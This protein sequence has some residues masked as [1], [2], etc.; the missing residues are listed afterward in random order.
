[1][2]APML[3]TLADA[4]LVDPALVYEPKYDGMR[5]IADV[6]A[7]GASVTLWSRLGNNKTTQFPE[8]V[9][10][11]A[12]WA[13]GKGEPIVL[14]GELVALDAS[15]QPAGFGQLQG[16]LQ[17]REALPGA[18]PTA[19]IAFDL[20]RIGTHDLRDHP[21]SVR[22]DALEQLFGRTQHTALRLSEQVAGDGR[23]L[24]ERAL[25]SGWEGL[26]AKH[27]QSKYRSG[28]RSADWRKL[29][30]V[31][32]QEFVVCGWTAPRQSRTHFGALVL[33]VH[34]A[35]TLR[36]AGS[37]GTGFDEQE[38]ARLMA[39]LTP[40]ETG[41][42]PFAD[43]PLASERP[44]WVRPELVVQVK[45]SEWTADHHLRHPVYIGLRTDAPA[46]AVV[47][48]SAARLHASTTR[49]LP[50]ATAATAH[51]I[52]TDAVGSAGTAE[53]TD[54]P[55]NRTRK[56]AARSRAAAAP[57]DA[58]AQADV[59]AEPAV[60]APSDADIA[61]LLEQVDA[62]ERKRRDGVL[63]LPDGTSLAVTNLTKLFWPHLGLTKGDLFRYYIQAAP[64]ILPVLADRALVMKRFPNGVHGDP[65]YQHRA[66][67]VPPGI[68]VQDIAAADGQPQ[69]VG[70]DLATLLYTCQLAAI[71]QDPWFSQVQTSATPDAMALDL[72]PSD[73]VPFEQVLDVARWIREELQTFGVFAVPKT[74]G[75][76]GL[77]IFVPL[78]PGT[79][80]EAGR[81]FC[82]IVA[83]LV[84]E[85]HPQ[86]ATIERTVRA[87]GA[88]VY[89]DYLQNIEGKTLASAY[90]ARASDYA[91]VST[92]L[93]W[94]EVQ[95]GVRREDFTISTVPTRLARVGDLWAPLRQHPGLDLRTIAGA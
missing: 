91:G 35:G 68:R 29:K 78:T 38:L 3:A 92:P 25:A 4:P 87:R 12:T 24:Y 44:H 80:Y 71:S 39:L 77:H 28:K 18:G 9:Q 2:L 20:L 95:R 54:A 36:F 26:I 14:D 84:C 40:L 47:R 85:K 79:P 53:A 1:M 94:D 63:L 27:A 50:G 48:E 43:V 15:G 55:R 11:L 19:F 13:R 90:S 42:C 75:A 16:R 70:G 5:I 34:D 37:V 81:L 67:H 7:H 51:A 17:T 76:S 60:P 49:R 89:V 22:R 88:R 83:T 69:L 74:S 64:F 93:T 45:F 21:L 86:V 73:G 32:E 6:A 56:A 61:L 41:T 57:K 52:S 23:A 59:E 66:L 10:A 33:G 30:I 72:D 46:H 62:L 58:E 65:F 31:Q 8:V 82:Q